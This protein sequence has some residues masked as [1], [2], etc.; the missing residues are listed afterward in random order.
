VSEPRVGESMAMRLMFAAEQRAESMVRGI[1]AR[2][3]VR[4]EHDA[5]AD[6]M[7]LSKEV[8]ACTGR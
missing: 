7:T 1:E 3:T 5:R 2:R 8:L 6:F 4:S